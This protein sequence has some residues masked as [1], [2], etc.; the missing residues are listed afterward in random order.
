MT[1]VDR[2]IIFEDTI[3]ITIILITPNRTY[4]S[5]PRYILK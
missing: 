2:A 4:T 3:C 1:G 5:I